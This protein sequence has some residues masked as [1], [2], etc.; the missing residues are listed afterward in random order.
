LREVLAATDVG[1]PRT[2]TGALLSLVKQRARLRVRGL[3][4]RLVDPARV[5]AAERIEVEACWSAGL[6]LSM[7]DS[8]RARYFQVRHELAALEL[9]DPVNVARGLSSHVAAL[10]SEGG[11]A[12]REHCEEILDAAESLARRIDDPSILMLTH[13]CAGTA[14]Y[15][16]GD[17]RRAVERFRAAQKIGRERC[18]GVTWEMNSAELLELWALAYLGDLPELTLRL[19]RL[20]T[21]A[22]ERDD[23]FAETGLRLGL[24]NMTW[25][26]RDRPDDADEHAAAAMQRWTSSG[27][28]SQHYF[29]LI[30][31]A[32]TAL[33]RG[34]ETAA[35]RLVEAAWPELDRAHL[36]RLQILR[37]ELHHLRARAALAGAGAA[38]GP[39]DRRRLLRLAATDASRIAREDMPWA[40]PLSELVT[41]G[42]SAMEG[43]PREA[44]AAL[45]RAARGFDALE[46]ALYAAAARVQRGRL[47]GGSEGDRARAWLERQ[48][49]VHPARMVQMLVPGVR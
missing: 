23:V 32:Q 43:R 29:A 3:G 7:V 11:A 8:V 10:G 26:A 37:V 20:L 18:V 2:P 49:I 38:G 9:G 19:P 15:F 35:V 40:A 36:L 33:Y 5:P 34:D 27:F 6:G 45:D 48:G 12:N 24:P 13:F 4:F 41:A 28:H 39:R 16:S 44:A 30:A 42:V 21:E 1:Y 14:A 22:R 31:T 47:T 17:W 46:M 25:L